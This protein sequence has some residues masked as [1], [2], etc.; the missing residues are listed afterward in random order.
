MRTFVRDR[1]QRA[2]P[3]SVTGPVGASLSRDTVSADGSGRHFTD[4]RLP[5]LNLGEQHE[6][7]GQEQRTIGWVKGEEA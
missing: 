6:A 3:L 1:V 4:M 7:N 5:A 2:R